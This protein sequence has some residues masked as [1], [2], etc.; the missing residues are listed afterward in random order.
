VLKK[1]KIEILIAATIKTGKLTG[2]FFPLATVS[3]S[4]RVK[5]EK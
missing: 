4:A 5:N 3:V 2:S 1:L